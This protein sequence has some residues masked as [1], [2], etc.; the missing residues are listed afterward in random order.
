MCKMLFGEKEKPEV[1]KIIII[2]QQTIKESIALY[3]E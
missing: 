3:Y 1:V 2:K